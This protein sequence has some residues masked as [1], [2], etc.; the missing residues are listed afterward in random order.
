M[1][2]EL[3][4]WKAIADYFGTSDRTVQRWERDLALPVRRRG[5]AKGS[6]VVASR[7]E[8]DEWRSSPAGRQA[9]G[10][11]LDD[12]GPPRLPSVSEI[13]AD[14]H[15][16]GAGSVGVVPAGPRRFLSLV[17]R[18][19]PAA[20]AFIALGLLLV[21]AALWYWARTVRRPEAPVADQRSA[22]Q[23]ANPDSQ[24]A[25]AAAV[26]VLKLTAASGEVWSIRVIDGAMATWE[27]TAGRT[28][29]L[30]ASIDG[31]HLRVTLSDIQSA[32]VGTNPPI[33]PRVLTLVQGA[34]APIAHAG[35]NMTL[36]WTATEGRSANAP[37]RSNVVP[38]RCCVVCGGVT[39]CATEVTGWCGSCCDPR[40]TSCRP[41]L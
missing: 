5:N 18:R 23:A 25:G 17:T 13:A 41:P 2:D 27:S 22:S 9:E 16:R 8:L 37:A 14:A 20:G 39:V 6:A 11:H 24:H 15:E 38:P 30:S 31:T 35:T 32:D 26:A 4:G 12:A 3:R 1:D 10:E 40:F 7:L 33:L 34:A 21:G 28:L 19:R 36:E 29:G